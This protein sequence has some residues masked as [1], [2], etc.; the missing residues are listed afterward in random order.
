MARLLRP[1]SA[2]VPTTDDGWHHSQCWRCYEQKCADIRCKTPDGEECYIP[3]CRECHQLRAVPDGY[4][5]FPR[6]EYCRF[7]NAEAQR[8]VEGIVRDVCMEC[9]YR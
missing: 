7:C 3:F 9:F 4:K 2:R 5:L 8:R 1:P 6:C